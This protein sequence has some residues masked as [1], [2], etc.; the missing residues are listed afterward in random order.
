MT[1]THTPGRANL[2][3]GSARR[4]DL[5]LHN[6]ETTQ[7]TDVHETGG[8]RTRNPSKRAAAD[9]HLRP[10]VQC[11]RWNKIQNPEKG[12]ALGLAVL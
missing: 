11:D 9:V 5:Y 8:A 2:D 10:R 3:E 1:H 7:E 6:T 4:R 12:K